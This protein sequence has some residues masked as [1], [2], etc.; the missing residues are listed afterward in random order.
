VAAVAS[1]P[2]V[3]ASGW[4]E[5]AGAMGASAGG[6]VASGL[7]SIAANK[8]LAVML[9]PVVL[10]L[11]ATLGQI[12]DTAQMAATGNGKTALVQGASALEGAARRD[13]LRTAAAIFAGATALVAG[14]LVAAPEAVARWSGLPVADAPL[15]GGL[16]A[17][18]GLS[19]LFLFLLGLLNAL[20]AVHLGAIRRMAVLQTAGPAALALIA[21]PVA[22][23]IERGHLWIVPGRWLFPVM[24]A[25]AA[26]VAVAGAVAALSPYRPTLAA[27]LRGSGSHWAS[28]CWWT[29]AACRHFFSIS[30]AMLVT[31]LAASAALLTVRG[32]ILRREGLAAAGQFGAAWDI[33]MNHVTLVLASVQTYY[34]PTLARL[35]TPEERAAHISRVLSLAAPAAA[36]VIAVIAV[37]KPLLL[38]LF[39]SDAFRP[40]AQYLRWTLLGDYLRITAWLLS[41]PMLAAADMRVFLLTDL[42]AT[43]VFLASAVLLAAHWPASESAAVAF[44]L[45]NAVS[46]ALCAVYARR[47]HGFRWSAPAGMVWTAGLALVAVAS[48]LTWSTGP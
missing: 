4:R 40:A 47:R 10:A 38:T 39:Y 28:D 7:L 12:R 15:V 11:Y 25:A 41:V 22:R 42:T 9:G 5:L 18:L 34:L 45:M 27:W 30:G 3:D 37:A 32:N 24:L 35:R 8:I 20:G 14:L 16:A 26:A 6:A 17:A 19:S 23:G 48:S 2:A 29:T 13:Y 36:A 44:V 31:G 21:W 43:G 33:S 46:L 1:R